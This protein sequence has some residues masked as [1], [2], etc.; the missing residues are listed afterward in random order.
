M[1]SSHRAAP[2]VGQ[3]HVERHLGPRALFDADAL[4]LGRH[5]LVGPRD[6]EKRR[7]GDCDDRSMLHRRLP[8]A[9]AAAAGSFEGAPPGAPFDAE[10]LGGDS[11]GCGFAGAAAAAGAARLCEPGTNPAGR[12]CQPARVS[13][14]ARSSGM[15]P[16]LGAPPSAAAQAPTEPVRRLFE[17][18]LNQGRWEVF[19]QVHTKDF[20]AHAGGRSF[21]A[22]EDLEAAKE[23]R[24]GSPDARITLEHMFAEKDC[25]A[26][27]YR[28]EGTHT[29][30]WG[31]I[32]ATGKRFSARGQVIFRLQDAKIAEEWGMPDMAALMRSLGVLPP[33]S[34]RHL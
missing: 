26:V 16:E 6:A 9:G 24:T 27:L 22:A 25:V 2:L 17:E 30:P 29:G 1:S 4:E 15:L 5:R 3:G 20:V 12:L 13:S 31:G 28:V 34:P 21:S 11:P 33:A 14:I 32:P 19:E 18:E 23:N 8:G 7:P 10:P